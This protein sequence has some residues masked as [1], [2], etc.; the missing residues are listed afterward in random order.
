MIEAVISQ[1]FLNK[2]EIDLAAIEPHFT[3]N[4]AW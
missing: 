4:Q 2:S 3:H 1:E